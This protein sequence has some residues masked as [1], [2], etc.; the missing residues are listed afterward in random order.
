MGIVEYTTKDTR[1]AHANA[2]IATASAAGIS[3]DELRTARR[4]ARARGGVKRVL[5]PATAERARVTVAGG[6]NAER[7]TRIGV[8]R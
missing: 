8:V 5:K 4:E 3:V 1:S 2:E 7:L 6:V